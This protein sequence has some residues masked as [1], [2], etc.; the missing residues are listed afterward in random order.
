MNCPYN[1][2]HISKILYKSNKP[3]NHVINVNCTSLDYVK[4]T[5]FKCEECDLIF[6]ALYNS[7]L[8]VNYSEVVDTVYVDQIKSKKKY[9]QLVVS[10][11]EEYLTK[12]SNVL[13]IGSYYGVLGS[14]LKP[15]VKEYIGIELS[16]HGADFSK[17]NFNLKIYND[18]FEN[19]IKFKSSIDVI[20]M[21]HVIE[22][23]GNP[24]QIIKLI[25]QK[26][27][28]KSTLIFSTYN[29]DSL[30]ARI[31]GYNYQWIMPMHLYYFSRKTL[32][33]ILQDNNLKIVKII[34][35]VHI[36]SLK[37]FFLKLS[38]LV[39]LIGSLFLFMSKIKIFE[40]FNIKINLG[41]V[42]IYFVKKIK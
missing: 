28:L 1:Q 36:V 37:Y 22:H 34:Q 9:F 39:P 10:K 16:K 12:E 3:N 26:M 5:L 29:M 38:A 32:K 6:S 21:S 17:K 13:E 4:P 31:L 40:K 41:D 19:Y 23:L 2:K 35:D 24:F 8:E 20:I 15:R 14:L 7:P 42:D 33:K 30:I 27:N 18:K 25:E 11:I